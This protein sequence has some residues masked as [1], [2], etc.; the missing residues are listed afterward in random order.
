MTQEASSVTIHSGACRATIA[1]RGAG[2]S[3]L[4]L[5]GQD[6][7]EGYE[8]TGESSE[9][10]FFANLVLAP[11][12]NRTDGAAFGFAGERHQLEITEP[13][14]NTALHGLVADRVWSV[15]SATTDS[16]ELGLTV[17]GEPGWPWTF[18]VSVTYHVTD[19]GLQASF[20]LRN[21]AEK[22]MPA[23]CGFHLYPSALGAPTDDCTLTVPD[24]T[25]LPLDARGLPAGPERDD[26]DGT[27]ETG[28]LPARDNRLAGALL[29]HCLHLVPGD[30][31]PQFVLRHPDGAGVAL[32]TSPE[33]SW[34]QIF[35]PD[36]AAGMPYPGRPDGRAVAVEPMTAPPDA[37]NSGVDLDV[38]AP[39]Q[40][41]RCSWR[42]EVA[43][44][45]T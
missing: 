20:A 45:P 16:V 10:P 32:T 18:H 2:P 33:L 39:G 44:P 30:A 11:W 35:T 36:A 28:V 3:S 24:R 29:D 42:V 7:L 38:V 19:S 31:P 6:L 14:K 17:S 40:S 15:E 22:P 23:A 26:T 37:L 43:P 25:V 27:G 34:F 9:A 13:E 41:L 5:E 1:T 8:V 12:P 4:T 21:D